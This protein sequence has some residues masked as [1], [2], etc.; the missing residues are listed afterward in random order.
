MPVAGLV[1]LAVGAWVVF[2]IIRGGEQKD[3]A[4]DTAIKASDSALQAAGYQESSDELKKAIDQAGSTEEKAAIYTNLAVTAASA[5][6]MSEAIVYMEKKH[7]LAPGTA[8][9]DAYLMGTY[10][11]R[12][13]DNAKAIKQYKMAVSY[14]KSL[15]KS[16]TTDAKIRSLEARIKSLGG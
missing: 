14:N 3:G 12:A 1:L 7:A 8:K 2:G 15:P 16:S 11:E 13:G 4:L 9:S 6:K 10:Y 5:G